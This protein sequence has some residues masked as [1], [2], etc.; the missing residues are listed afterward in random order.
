M[1]LQLKVSANR[2]QMKS[3]HSMQ[4]ESGATR[5][6]RSD[7]IT[8]RKSH[9][10]DDCCCTEHRQTADGFTRIDRKSDYVPGWL[11]WTK[12]LTLTIANS[13]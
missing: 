5:P 1:G 12:W 13:N 7:R 3:V 9:C 6:T 11:A 4:Y 2:D 8:R 10:N